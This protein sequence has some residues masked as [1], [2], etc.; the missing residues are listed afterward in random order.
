VII[1]APEIMPHQTTHAWD[2]HLG[3]WLRREGL[4]RE[5]YTV[6]RTEPGEMPRG[7]HIVVDFSGAR[8]KGTPAMVPLLGNQ[9]FTLSLSSL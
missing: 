5:V 4:D 9:T 7:R 6:R 3:P 8:P 2:Q 1:D